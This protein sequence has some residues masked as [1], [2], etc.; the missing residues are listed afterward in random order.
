M[1]FSDLLRRRRMIRNYTDEP[2]S[3]EVIERIADTARR[4]PSAGFS[5]GHRIVAVTD[6]DLRKRIAD[7]SSEDEY[8]ASGLPRWLSAAP[9]QLVLCVDE[10]AYHDRYREA[11]KVTDQGLE[12]DWPVPYWFVDA[13]AAMMLVLLAAVEEGLGA[14]FFGSHRLDGI[15]ELLGIPAGVHPIGVV[16]IGHRADAQPGGSGTRRRRNDL[17]TELRWN[18]WD[19]TA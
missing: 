16:T 18:G 2:V 3:R 8:V 19:T 11:D 13:G 5:Q 15:K 17:A 4:A 7:L 9:V 1:E 14:G 10:Q 12:D 6:P